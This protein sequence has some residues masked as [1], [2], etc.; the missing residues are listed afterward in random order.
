MTAHFPLH[1]LQVRT[2]D[3]FSPRPDRGSLLHRVAQRWQTYRERLRVVDELSKASDRELRDIGINRYD[4]GR[5]FDPEFE[6]RAAS[7]PTRLQAEVR[8]TDRALQ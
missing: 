2:D 1:T 4:I 8:L 3:M 6:G 7:A 5:L